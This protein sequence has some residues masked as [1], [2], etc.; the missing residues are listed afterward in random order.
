[1]IKT[2]HESREN[3][4]E[5]RNGLIQSGYISATLMYGLT[6]DELFERIKIKKSW[7]PKASDLK[8]VADG[9]ETDLSCYCLQYDQ[10]SKSYWYKIEDLQ[11]MYGNI[12][13]VAGKDYKV[14]GQISPEPTVTKRPNWFTRLLNRLFG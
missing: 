8:R 1:M 3:K 6:D 10:K 14:V 11:K 7:L 12:A 5:V 9:I 2:I 4:Q 13:Y